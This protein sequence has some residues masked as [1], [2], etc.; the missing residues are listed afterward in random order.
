MALIEAFVQNPVKVAVGVLLVVLFGF[1]ARARMPM[2]LTPEVQIPTITVSTRW[3][4][5][6]PQEI[7]QEIVREQEE[8]LQSVEGVTKLTSESQDSVGTISM[9]FTVGTN[10]EEALLKVNSRLQQVPEYPIDADQPVI[11]ASGAND[12]P[13][14]WFILSARMPDDASLQAFQALHPELAAGIET[15]RTANNPGLAAFHMEALA[16]QHAV[17][18]RLLM[19]LRLDR[20][21]I[22]E[23][24]KQ[25]PHTARVLDAG[26]GRGTARGRL[27]VA[28]AGGRGVSGSATARSTGTDRRPDL[29]EVRRR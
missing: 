11:S 7:E 16:E 20:D 25:F 24:R 6:S 10:M 17:V 26:P 14:A 9:E 8:F 2:Q 27:P 18:R 21:R 1:I 5:A 13:I 12:R 29:P 19:G 28:A 4:G 15:V 23:F 3:P 22:E